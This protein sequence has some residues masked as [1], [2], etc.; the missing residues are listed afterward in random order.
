MNM[1]LLPFGEMSETIPALLIVPGE[2]MAEDRATQLVSALSTQFYGFVLANASI[3]STRIA[4]TVLTLSQSLEQ[5][6]IKRIMFLGV[7]LGSLV[8]LAF[9]I[10]FPRMVRR[11]ILLD[12]QSRLQ[13]VGEKK[14]IQFL[15]EL[16][17]F[18]LPLRSSS[19]DFD[20]R[21]ALHRVR[22]PTLL[23]A[24][25]QQDKFIRSEYELLLS[26][27]P[28]AWGKQLHSSSLV[29]GAISTEITTLAEQFLSVP[30]KKPQ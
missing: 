24:S 23:L 18:G 26:Q 20:A 1:N 7:G 29:A 25:P 2:L 19:K 17:P 15:D 10:R 8:S 22:C 28:N 13:P 9:A 12:G 6:K 5:K 27:I 11:I 30:T 4:D 21:P 14:F 16:L 3:D